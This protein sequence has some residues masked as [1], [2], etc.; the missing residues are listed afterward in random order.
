LK[1]PDCSDIFLSIMRGGFVF[2]LHAVLVYCANR[3]AEA[4]E[5]KARDLSNIQVFHYVDP[6]DIIGPPFVGKAENCTKL[7]PETTCGFKSS[8]NIDDLSLQVQEYLKSSPSSV[9]VSLYNYATLTGTANRN[10]AVEPQCKRLPTL[11]TMV[12]SEGNY[13]LDFQAVSDRFDGTTFLSSLSSVK[14]YNTQ[15]YLDRNLFLHRNY[16]QLKP[17]NSL[18]KASAYVSGHCLR[19]GPG[20]GFMKRNSARDNVVKMM[21]Q[22]GMRVDG[23]GKCLRSKDG[24]RQNMLSGRTNDTFNDLIKKRKAISNYLFYLAFENQIEP[25][26]VT[27]LVFDALYAGVVPVFLGDTVA[28]KAIL[29]HPQAAIFLQD[30]GN[31]HKFVAYLQKL[32]NDEKAYEKHRV[33]RVKYDRDPESY[34][35]EHPLLKESWPCSVCAWAQKWASV[36]GRIRKNKVSF[37]C[38]AEHSL[39]TNQS[40]NEL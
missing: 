12:E 19:S 2:L 7:R 13:P 32:M 5:E 36:K 27:H 31:T 33:W 26:Y 23:L 30:F 24:P 39:A 8:H 35:R 34:T 4:L 10:R 9:S 6:R 37:R 1:F 18:L 21:R 29:P 40:A 17:F 14:R 15:A 11:L 20:G 28:C 25:W 16:S 3:N 38:A 22:M